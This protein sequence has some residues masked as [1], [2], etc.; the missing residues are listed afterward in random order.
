MVS[1]LEGLHC[2]HKQNTLGTIRVLTEDLESSFQY[3][4]WPE[5]WL[6]KV[7]QPHEH[8]GCKIKQAHN[9]TCTHNQEY[10]LGT[11]RVFHVSYYTFVFCCKYFT[12]RK[13]NNNII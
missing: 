7:E 10:T 5:H 2:T 9:N 6:F 8:E 11:I 4:L 12:C 3:T 1:G 13:W